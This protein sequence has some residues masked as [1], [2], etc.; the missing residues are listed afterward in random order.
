[1]QIEDFINNCDFENVTMSDTEKV[2]A[3]KTRTRDYANR[4]IHMYVALPKYD[5]AQILGKQLLRSG[6]SIGA[7]YREACRA[8]SNAEFVSKLSVA[9]QELDESDYWLD[10]IGMNGIFPEKRLEPL[11]L[12]TNELMAMIAASLRTVKERE[13]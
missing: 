10:L 13:D 5:L 3:F 4:I 7:H 8:R 9:L 11:R 1:L 6:T 12:E 2:A